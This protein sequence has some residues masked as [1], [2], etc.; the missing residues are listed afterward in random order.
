M[1]GRPPTSVSGRYTR[2]VSGSTA[3]PCA[4]G[5]ARLIVVTGDL[6]E[7][8][9]TPKL[10]ERVSRGLVERRQRQAGRLPT[11]AD[12]GEAIAAAALDPGLPSGHTVAVG[13]DPSS[14]LAD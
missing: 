3:T 14:L 9:A 13:A 11:A 8:T 5:P 2:W 1:T 4:S 6:V 10:L 7:G 12:M